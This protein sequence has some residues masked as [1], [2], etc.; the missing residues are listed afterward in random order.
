MSSIPNSNLNGASNLD[1]K[2][3]RLLTIWTIAIATLKIITINVYLI[4]F[5]DSALSNSMNLKLIIGADFILIST[6][7]IRIAKF[8]FPINS[9]KR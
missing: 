1:P 9:R 2:N 5:T 3:R 8:Y 4:C 7:L 6:V